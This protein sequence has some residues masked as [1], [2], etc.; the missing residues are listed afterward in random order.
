MADSNPR[1]SQRSG[2]ERDLNPASEKLAAHVAAGKRVRDLSSG[3]P[4][5]VGLSLGELSLSPLS[6]RALLDYQPAPFG[7]L[8]AR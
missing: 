5:E 7:P 3:N 4:T 8:L 2:L 1:F 6:N